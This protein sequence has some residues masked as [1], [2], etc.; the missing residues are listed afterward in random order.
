MRMTLIGTAMLLTVCV[1]GNV[2]GHEKTEGGNQ[3][4]KGE[5]PLQILRE[6]PLDAES[7]QDQ[8]AEL[9]RDGVPEKFGHEEWVAVVMAHELHQHVGIMT[10]LGA[11]MGVR[12][13][14]ILDAP[15]RSIM[16]TVETGANPPPACLID[17][18]QASI[19]STLAQGLITIPKTEKPETAATFEHKGKKVRLSLKP[20]YKEKV[21]RHIKSAIGEHGNLTPA[22]FH[23]IEHFSY[24]VWS[25]FDRGEIFA[26]Q[27]EMKT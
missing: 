3:E 14:E 15:T 23:E 6:F 21:Q 11:K 2:L 13:R 26:E 8:A 1:C 16:V 25:R 17:G 19:G 5:R 4:R 10:V 27:L 9:V 20:E 24:Y 22:Y 18:I 7:Y 12:A